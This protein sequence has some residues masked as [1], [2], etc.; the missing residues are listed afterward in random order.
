MKTPRTT[1]EQ[2]RTLQA[3]VEQG[4]YVQAAQY[5][6]R[7]QSSVSYAINRLEEQLQTEILVVKGRK[8]ELTDAGRILLQRSR[9]IVTDTRNLE[10]LAADLG[11]GREAELRLVIDE[12]FPFD[13]LIKSL[14]QFHLDCG[15]TRIILEQ[16]ILSGADD[17][18]NQG[19]AD[20]AIT[21][22]V[23]ANM[24]GDELTQIKF[25]A[26]AHPDHPLHKLGADITTDQLSDEMQIVIRDSGIDQKRDHG[27]LDAKQQWTVSSIES[28]LKLIS[29]GM[30][31]GW[32]PEHMISNQLE[33]GTLKV[34]PLREGKS[35]TAD[36]FLVFGNQRHVGPASQQLADILRACSLG[37]SA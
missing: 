37:I 35:Y 3:V 28:S 30:G 6:H 5:L 2:W 32:L 34:L 36:L 19:Q 13:V 8:A 17:F 31:F 12:A 26:V 20:I 24:L 9:S 15:H 1:I 29:Q 22:C 21:H 16:V 7:S 10:L 33:N 14:K 23:P 11:S 4:G 25:F 18:L 27:W